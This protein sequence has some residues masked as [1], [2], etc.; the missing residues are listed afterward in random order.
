MIKHIKCILQIKNIFSFIYY[1]NYNRHCI[2]ILREE[3]IFI[4]LNV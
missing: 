4:L 3:I 2:Y 1:V